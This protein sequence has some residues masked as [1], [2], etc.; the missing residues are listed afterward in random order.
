MINKQ[1]EITRYEDNIKSLSTN[2]EMLGKVKNNGNDV[3]KVT[4]VLS[5]AIPV[6]STAIAVLANKS[7]K[8]IAI[9]AIC[10]SVLAV[11]GAYVSKKSIESDNKEIDSKISDNL[12]EINTLSIKKA[13]LEQGMDDEA[14]LRRQKRTM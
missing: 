9:C 1:D 3:I 8:E 7:V 6:A 12:R 11:G 10:S 14:I 2:I 5:S 4:N 13:L